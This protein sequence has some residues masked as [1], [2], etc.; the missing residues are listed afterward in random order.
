MKTPWRMTAALAGV[1]LA[2][3]ACGTG[4]QATT[5]PAG[6][7][8]ADAT[9]TAA[10]E[11]SPVESEGPRLE[12]ACGNETFEGETVPIQFQLQWFPQAQFAGYFAAN[13]LGCYSDVGL[14]VEIL[15]GA[16]DIAPQVVVAAEDGPEF[17]EAWVP[18]VLQ[19]RA[20]GADLV[21]IAQIFQRSGT[22]HVSFKEKNITSP[23]DW[24]GMRIGDWGF[25]NELEV[26]AAAR[27][28]G[29]EPGVDYERVAQDFDMTELINDEIDSAEAMI[30]NEYAQL[31]ET[32]NEETGD[33]YQPDDLNIIDFNDVGVA[34]LQDHIIAR[35]SWLAGETNGV[36]NEE[37]AV[38]FLT[39]SFKGWMICREDP[40]QCVEITTASGSQLPAGHQAWMMNEINALIWPSP[41]GI[42]ILDEAAFQQTL[43]ICMQF[44]A[45]PAVTEAVAEGAF[46][47]DL[48][49]QAVDT[50]AEFDTTGE[51]FEK[52]E[53]EVTPGGE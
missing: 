18:K 19:A 50:L 25:G 28:A 24:A 52:A 20:Q 32:A 10:T 44:C 51:D 40:E 14:E 49:Q 41:N 35:E 16:V 8:T 1:I 36:P 13:E 2:V 23:E 7:Q 34:M 53:I 31:L 47:T 17:G 38:R 11:A 33:L 48:A 22:L 15:A 3:T 43:D 39:A 30:Y 6:E 9:E 42:G 46:R 29:L 21:N 26:F 27:Q 5:S 45:D 37:I 12:S 4:G